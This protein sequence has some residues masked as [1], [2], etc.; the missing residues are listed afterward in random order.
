M[1]KSLNT[2]KWYENAWAALIFFTRVPFYRLYSPPRDSYRAVVEF[3]PLAGWFTASV[4]A[5]TLYF[6]SWLFPHSVAVALAILARLLLTGALHED[7]LADF[8]DGFGGGNDRQRILDIMKDSRIGTYGVLGLL[9]Y[10]LL[11]YL[12]LSSLPVELATLTILCADPYAKML[13]GQVVQMM[14]YARTEQEAKARV[15]YR[16]IS[17]PAAV[18]LAVQGLLPVALLFYLAPNLRGQ[19]EI[20]LFVPCLTMY[21]LYRIIW[22]K[23]RGYTGDCCGAIFLIVELSLYLTMSVLCK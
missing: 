23:L 11:L 19:W 5:G 14:P 22:S 18:G 3:W 17:I 10:G 6:G 12:A 1:R 9:M 7:G 4:M 8:C 21:V 2:S 15:V 13:G 16:K 20:I